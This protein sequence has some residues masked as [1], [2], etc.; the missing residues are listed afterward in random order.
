ME[1]FKRRGRGDEAVVFSSSFSICRLV[2]HHAFGI[3]AKSKNLRIVLLVKRQG[4][5][6]SVN[7]KN[8]QVTQQSTHGSTGGG[9][10]SREESEVSGNGDA[11]PPQA[12][13]PLSVAKR[14]EANVLRARGLVAVIL[15][16][17]VVSVATTTNLIVKQQERSEF[18]TKFEAYATEV[19]TVTGSNI[20]Q[21]NEA[22]DSFAS[23]IGAQAATEHGLRNTSWPFYRIPKWSVQV[24]KLA[25]LTGV[26][27]ILISLAPIVEEDEREEWNRFATEQNPLW[28]QESIETEGYTKFT[29]QELVDLTVPFTFFLDDGQPLPVTRP[30]E[31]L[32]LFQSYPVGPPLGSSIMLTNIDAILSS[33]QTEDVYRIAKVTR[34]FSIGF[35][36]IGIGSK[37][38]VP[39]SQIVQPIFDGPNTNADDRKMVAVLLIQLPWVDYLKNVLAEGEDGIIVIIETFCPTFLEDGT[40]NL[41]NAERNIVTYQV[42]GPD[43]VLLGE[44]D[45]HDPE[46]DDL[47]VR[48]E[49]RGLPFDPSELPAG[50][51]VPMQTIRIYPSAE[52]EDSYRTNN[53]I[54]YTVVVVV[55][56]VFTTLVFLLYDFSVG[57][58]QRAVM[59]RIMKQ[60]RI[61]A[62]VFPTAI[63]D[64]L[65]ENQT[66]NMV[67]GDDADLEE[68]LGLDNSFVDKSSG[69]DGSAPL[70]ELFPSVTLVF[71]D[72]VNFTAWSSAREPHH[73]F[74]L[75]E[76][77]YGAFDK[78]AYRHGVF[79]V[80]TVGDC[81]V[82]AVGLPEPKDDHAVVACRFAR[83][84]IK[85]MKDATLKL[86]VSL[87]PDTSDLEIRTGMH[88]GQVTAGVLRGQRSRFQLFGDTVNTASRMESSG[89]RNRIQISQATA[90]LLTEAGLARWI[91][92]RSSTINVKGKGEMQT[93]W[94]CK[95]HR[96]IQPKTANMKS[97]METLDEGTD[98]EKSSE[99]GEEGDSELLRV[100]G[101]NRT[102]RL[103]EWNAKVLTSLLQQIVGS[104]GGVGKKI[105]TLSDAESRIGIRGKT[106]LDEFIPIIPLKRFGKEE[107]GR[108]QSLTTVDIGEE[109]KSQLRHYISTIASMYPDNAFHNF[110]HACHVTTSVKKLLARI[111]VVGEENGFGA[112]ESANLVDQSGHSY[113]ITSDPLTQFAVVFSAIIHDVDHPGV[114]NAQ[115]VKEKSQC[116]QIY[117]KSVAEQKS[118]DIAWEMLMEDGYADLRACIYQT[119]DDL[120]RFRQLVVN[121]VMAT[122]IVD[123]ELQA[124]R[125]AR[126]ETAFDSTAEMLDNGVE[127]EDRKATIVIEHLI[128][129]SDVA[130]TMQHWY[131][132]KKWN[133]RFFMECYGAYKEGR[134][135]SDPS[136]NWYKEEIGFFDHY[137]IPLA[138]KLQSCGV[139]G[140]SSHE[141]LNYAT[142]NR[143]EWVREGEALVQQFL[144]TFKGG[145][146]QLAAPQDPC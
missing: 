141:Y 121:T 37:N 80:E 56:F 36:K 75:L 67:A 146:D 17:A 41:K 71:A 10:E 55:I 61:V 7:S 85:K 25:Q 32:P 94:V 63:R 108:R 54:I 97:Q 112:T 87:G 110:E 30:G 103:V 18:E 93:Y 70:A 9:S 125:K 22:L 8:S 57:R 62:D 91:T 50:S 90:D 88:S 139:F 64:R 77:I 130:H 39:G 33:P 145:N 40:Q 120:R 81:Y 15:L 144:A 82:S 14:E 126:W 113:G 134:A 114:P 140:L 124:L 107:L 6:R 131:T 44:A 116:A 3:A 89:E 95:S 47:V 58:R 5:M 106:V 122:D 29:A 28:Y 142:A 53:D 111:V 104:R 69:R 83:D 51:C 143:D 52:L 45:L 123:R 46:Y 76:T 31:V 42:N 109:A 48:T 68:P 96:S 27:E 117:K 59:E 78:L 100:E 92:P 115:L 98:T 24:Q 132:Y 74:I 21:F 105:Q 136:T 73:V 119:E 19:L 79:K 49:S 1:F 4:G 13:T 23:S 128:Q 135:D 72:L 60:D 34:R 43:A 66:E 26:D 35:T 20:K 11:S 84:C 38:S 138:K 127:S 65:Y 101:M 99:M 118:V 102:E 133:E 16:L 12:Y 86:E 2:L 129:A 137:I